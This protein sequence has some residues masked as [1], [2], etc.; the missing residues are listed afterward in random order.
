MQ[1]VIFRNNRDMPLYVV[2]VHRSS[3]NRNQ[4][5][6]FIT[7]KRPSIILYYWRNYGL[8]HYQLCKGN[9]YALGAMNIVKLRNFT[10]INK[11][12]K[13][14]IFIPASPVGSV[15]GSASLG[16]LENTHCQQQSQLTLLSPHRDGTK[17][18]RR[19]NHSTL[20]LDDFW[21]AFL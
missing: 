11:L 20:S 15:A 16:G 1:A 19:C 6:F 12:F 13:A 9:L 10:V 5:C 4:N 21:A 17:Q 2:A 3:I 18:G 7:Q 14:L 8:P